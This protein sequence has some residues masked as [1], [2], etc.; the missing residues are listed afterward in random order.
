MPAGTPLETLTDDHHHAPSPFLS[1]DYPTVS[2]MAE[3]VYGITGPAAVAEEESTSEEEMLEDTEW[4][5]A[6]GE[7]ALASVSALRSVSAAAAEAP[8]AVLVTFF[9]AKLPESKHPSAAL[10]PRGGN[11]MFIFEVTPPDVSSVVP[12]TRW[13][14]DT[15]APSGVA[16]ESETRFGGWL[17]DV[18]SFDGGLF[19]IS[20]AEAMLMDPQHRLLLLQTQPAV[21]SVPKAVTGR[22][23]VFVGISTMVRFSLLYLQGAPVL[24]SIL[25]IQPK[26]AFP[27]GLLTHQHDGC[28][29]RS[30]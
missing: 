21:A 6:A 13:I 28:F 23:G 10:R 4:P 8:S 20:P 5:Y 19:A 16:T 12:G 25:A 24:G 22:F 30:M 11:G 2:S 29:H 17:T 26:L 7:L 18:A 14:A 27:E 9:D 3:F 1:F 15:P